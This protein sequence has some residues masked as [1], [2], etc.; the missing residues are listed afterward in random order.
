MVKIDLQLILLVLVIGYLV[1]FV[2]IKIYTKGYTLGA[3]DMEAKDTKQLI[4]VAA[5]LKKTLPEPEARGIEL[6][7]S[8]LTGGGAGALP[9][10]PTIKEDPSKTCKGFADK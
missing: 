6:L 8:T 5:Y 2:I 9:T 1:R 4:G 3:R 10:A 7:I